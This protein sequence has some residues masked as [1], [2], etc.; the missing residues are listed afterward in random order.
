MSIQVFRGYLGWSNMRGGTEFYSNQGEG[1]W[2][3]RRTGEEGEW[4]DLLVDEMQEAGA[5]EGC[6]VIVVS[7]RR[8]SG[9]DV[10]VLRSQIEDL[11]SP[12]PAEPSDA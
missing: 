6:D 9:V 8:L 7:V 4:G 1:R 10:D 3:K 12:T 11:I 5:S 2:G